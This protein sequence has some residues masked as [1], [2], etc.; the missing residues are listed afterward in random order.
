MPVDEARIKMSIKAAASLCKRAYYA[1][2]GTE[3]DR[4]TDEY[5]DRVDE[6]DALLLHRTILSLT[7]QD[8]P[9]EIIY[10]HIRA[11]RN[12]LDAH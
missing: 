5:L 7:G 9:V 1:P 11:E 12:E 4:L 10:A 6:K 3:R 2:A 8:L